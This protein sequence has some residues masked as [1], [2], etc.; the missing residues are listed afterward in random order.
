MSGAIAGAAMLSVAAFVPAVAQ[1]D[2]NIEEITVTAQKRSENIQDV[3]ISVTA[4]TAADLRA[5]NISKPT[6]LGAFVPGL[7]AKST[8]GDAN[9]VFTV[10]G[11]GLNDF[12]TNN[13]PNV[14]VYID[15]I[16][17]PYTPMLNMPLFDLDRVEVLKGPQGTLYGRN[18]T[19]GAIRFVT[20]KP[21][22]SE[23]TDGSVTAGDYG[24]LQAEAGTGGKIDDV[25]SFRV[26]AY[27][28]QQ[29]DGW[30]YDEYTHQDYSTANNSALRVQFNWHPG[31][32]FDLALE[33]YGGYENS[34][35]QLSQ[36]IGVFAAGTLAYP[37]APVALGSR[38]EGPCVAYGKDGKIYYNSSSNPRDVA[39]SSVYGNRILN[40]AAGASAEANWHLP[41]FTITSITGYAYNDNHTGND[42]DG[43]PLIL[44]DSKFE[45][46][47]YSLT[48]ELRATSNP[49]SWL[50][51]TTGIYISYDRTT[52]DLPQALDDQAFGLTRVLTRWV[53]RT[54]SDAA[55]GQVE[56]PILDRLS[57]T[58]GVR[59]TYEHREYDYGAYD[60]NPFGTSGFAAFDSVPVGSYLSSLNDTNV[61][62]K[63]GLNYKPG[64]GLL[65]YGSISSG[66]KGGGY[67]AAIEF[68]PFDL[69]PFKPEELVA[70]E[71]G[72]KTTWLD[73]KL[74]ADAAA[75][76]YDWRQFQGTGTVCSGT[77]SVCVTTL[78]N[79]GTAHIDGL[80]GQ[81][82]W[83]PAP[84]VELAAG[85]N[86]MRAHV[87]NGTYNGKTL[88]D[89]PRLN[90]TL[91]ARYENPQPVWN[92]LH[93]YVQAIVTGQSSE[94]FDSNNDELQ[95]QTGYALL[96]LRVGVAPDVGA[97]DFWLW[98]DNVTDAVYRNESYNSG[99]FIPSQNYYGPPATFGATL[100]FH[101]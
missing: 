5:F 97:W 8:S 68:S 90:Y 15:D 43:T 77:P 48:Q 56:V 25:L 32:D 34:E 67:K 87:I 1:G 59:L 78:T 44:L 36:D 37:C 31:D 35:N 92:S 66:F 6:D 47:V 98:A 54:Q 80:E 33:T 83:R 62:W 101:L 99:S 73:G 10:R 24:L 72:A 21:S 53:Q 9:P 96:N 85:G 11:I 55:F 76:Y 74:T 12:S 79:V 7:D 89:A 63:G 28:K 82:K 88:A 39:N 69:Q 41:D 100:A 18:N 20:K 14:S 94:F 17:L 93:P 2:A 42:S 84:G 13:N 81:L 26:S 61:S 38:N 52:G 71:L 58:G 4:L 30:Q 46:G 16:V 75:Y 70:Y 3:P 27:T 51:W 23:E 19:G 95:R 60:L 49:D 65:I 91:S 64:E 57:F 86:W 40:V 29:F 22:D 50:K 45:S